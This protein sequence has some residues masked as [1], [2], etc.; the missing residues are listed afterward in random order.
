MQVFGSATFSESFDWPSSDAAYDRLAQVSDKN[1]AMQTQTDNRAAA[2]LRHT[3]TAARS[4]EITVPVNCAIALW[5]TIST[6]DAVAGL[7]VAKRRVVG[8]ALR[9]ATGERN[10]YEQRL[11]LQDA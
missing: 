10:A 11:T 3:L 7:A 5:D 2:I 8:I 6:T 4:D 1:L 9:Y